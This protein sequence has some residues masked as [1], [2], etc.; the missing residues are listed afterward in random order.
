MEEDEILVPDE[1]EMDDILGKP[2]SVTVVVGNRKRTFWLRP[3]T[4]MERDM[5]R[6]LARRTVNELRDRLENEKTEE[7]DLLIRSAME[8]MT[9]DEKRLIWLTANLFQKTFELSRLSLENRDEYFVAEPEGKMEGIVP[10]SAKEVAD[11][12]K[13]KKASEKDRLNDLNKSQK[14][15]FAELKRESQELNIDDLDNLV[16]PLLVEERLGT[17]WNNQYGLQVLVRCTF[18]DEDLTKRSYETTERALRLFNTKQG[19]SAMEKLL[20]TH[21]ALM[22]DPD[23][24]KN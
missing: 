23:Q 9:P 16:R 17:E 22:L 2:T 12:D 19:K 21:T 24:L 3:P 4:D 1:L 14:D 7:H 6:A 5:A 8:E 10:P 11:Y 13:A 18:D 20:M 15:A